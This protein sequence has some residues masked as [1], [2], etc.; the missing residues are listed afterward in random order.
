[1]PTRQVAFQVGVVV[2]TLAVVAFAATSSTEAAPVGVL[3]FVVLIAVA[4]NTAVLLGPGAGISPS[5]LII[6]AAIATFEPG[7]AALSAVVVGAAA[8][9]VIETIRARRWSALI[10]NTSQ[11]VLASTAAAV[12]FHALAPQKNGMELFAALAAVLAF[13]V[14][15]YGLVIPGVSLLQSVSGREVWVEVRPQLPNYLAFGLVGLVVGLVLKE[16]GAVAIVLLVMP[17]V[18]SRLAFASFQR[19]H[20]S[21]E[22]AIRVFGRL[23]EAKDPYT[24]GHT[25]RVARYSAYMADELGLNPDEAAH[26]RH[27]ALMHDVGKL[28]VPSSLLNKPGRLTPEEWDVVRAH[29]DAG[30]GILTRVDFMRSM[31]VTAS[32]R[33]GHFSRGEDDGTPA[34]LV[35]EAH[36]VAVADAFDAMTSTRSYRLA[37]TQ[38][39]ACAELRDKAGT[40]FNP[41]CVEALIT[42]IE[43]RGEQYGRGFEV[44][45]HQFAVAPPDVGVGSAGLGDLARATAP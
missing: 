9:I 13:A 11:Y 22:A 16:I 33:H 40:Q 27:S 26:L 42:A 20:E 8:G 23:I 35:L 31:T 15:Q 19:S 28:A 17:V 2:A 37:L 30:I 44:D 3:A 39:V 10:L 32:D 24:A 29:N 18:I 12:L 43:R 4:E 25:Q 41:E 7:S 34:H 14:I 21:H 45:P 1:M 38:E 36:I 6:F 5:L